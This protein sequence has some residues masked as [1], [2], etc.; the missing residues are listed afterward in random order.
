QQLNAL[1]RQSHHQTVNQQDVKPN[2]KTKTNQ[3]VPG[4]VVLGKV[5]MRFDAIMRRLCNGLR[6]IGF[7]YLGNA[8]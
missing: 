2:D 8:D 1:A 5:Q 6:T 3:P 4:V 7:S